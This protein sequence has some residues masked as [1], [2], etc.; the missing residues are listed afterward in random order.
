MIQSFNELPWVP[1]KRFCFSRLGGERGTGVPEYGVRGTG[2]R[3]VENAG[4]G[5]HGFWW[6]TAESGG[7]YGVLVEYTGSEWKTRVF[8]EKKRKK[9]RGNHFFR[10]HESSSLK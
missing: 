9:T 3:G 8:S 7:K 4:C 10:Q 1:C 6:K 2:S 5:K